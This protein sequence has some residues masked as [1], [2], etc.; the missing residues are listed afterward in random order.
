[1]PILETAVPHLS[2]NYA[3]YGAPDGL[4]VIALHGMPNTHRM[5][6]SVDR[7]AHEY[8]IRI[9]APDRAGYG[10]TQGPLPRTLIDYAAHIAAF[11]DALKLDRFVI[12][13]ASGGG[14]YT[15]ACAAELSD[16]LLA[17]IIISSL[18]PLA[19]GG[20]LRNM[21]RMNRLVF[22][23]GRLSPTL[24]SRLLTRLLRAS[25][26]KMR[27]YVDSGT[28]PSPDLSPEIYALVVDD[29]ANVV[30]SGQKGITNDLKL[31]WHD[32]RIALESVHI[33][34]YLWHG[35]ADRLA[36]PQ[37]AHT[38]A[39]RLPNCQ[40]RFLPGEGHVEPLIRHMPEIFAPL[41][42]LQIQPELVR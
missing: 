11:V 32:W 34:V 10:D 8:G 41:R 2:I 22:T 7:A 6:K 35:E 37:G 3:E 12:L 9:I 4:P 15:Y 19:A 18:G 39:Q 29:M 17:A 36:P 13:G 20:M 5:W 33:P 23:L 27:S 24:T 31:Y 14:P 42:A 40:A 25:L 1:M 28:S 30:R 16:R 38:I 26:P 21:D